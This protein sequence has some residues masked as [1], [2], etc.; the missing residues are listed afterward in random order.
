M[1]P[2]GKSRL[3]DKGRDHFEDEEGRRRVSVAGVFKIQ[4]GRLAFR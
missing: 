2:D 4:K 3:S 1:L